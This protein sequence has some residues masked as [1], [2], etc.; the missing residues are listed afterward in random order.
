MAEE[1]LQLV[2]LGLSHT[3]TWEECS[4]LSLTPIPSFMSH[5]GVDSEAL[6]SQHTVHHLLA[7]GRCEFVF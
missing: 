1:T 7:S 5:Y 3:D 2:Q 4:G 6:K